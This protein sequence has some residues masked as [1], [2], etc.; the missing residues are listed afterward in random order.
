MA[1]LTYEKHERIYINI[2]QSAKKKLTEIA[3]YFGISRSEL[4]KYIILDWL[5][6]AEKEFNELKKSLSEGGEKKEET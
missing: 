3:R 2:P 5:F 1:S 6:Y 4:V